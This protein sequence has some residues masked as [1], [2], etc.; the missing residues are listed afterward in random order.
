MDR[1]VKVRI[2]RDNLRLVL[3]SRLEIDFTPEEI[4]KVTEM[5]EDL[6]TDHKDYSHSDLLLWA[7]ATSARNEKH[8]FNMFNLK[9]YKRNNPDFFTSKHVQI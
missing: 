4:E 2:V 7:L 3:K 6:K 5:L 9:D 1:L 8:R